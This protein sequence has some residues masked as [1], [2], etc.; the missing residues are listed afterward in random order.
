MLQWTQFVVW[1]I[2]GLIGGSFAAM[3]ATRQRGG[4]GLLSNIALGLGGALI[5]GFIFWLFSLW[6]VLDQIK[7]SARDVVASAIGSILI[8]LLLWLYRK[9]FV[10]PPV[11]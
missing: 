10:P 7:I 3:A 11:N 5:G 4:F 2:V 8:L 6:A 1:L 9:F